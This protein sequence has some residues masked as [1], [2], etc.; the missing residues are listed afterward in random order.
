MDTIGQNLLV[1]LVGVLVIA[2][3]LGLVKIAFRDQENFKNISPYAALLGVI[4]VVGSSTYEFGRYRLVTQ[5]VKES[6]P[7]PG[8]KGPLNI[9][10]AQQ[11]VTWYSDFA[12]WYLNPY[13]LISLAFFCLTGLLICAVRFGIIVGQNAVKLDHLSADE[14]T[15]SPSAPKPRRLQGLTRLGIEA[16]TR[17]R[18]LDWH[19]HKPGSRHKNSE[20]PDFEAFYRKLHKGGIETPP[21]EG[22]GLNLD[23]IRQ[24]LEFLQHVEPFLKNNDL[25]GTCE[26]AAAFVESLKVK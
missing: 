2:A 8:A 25:E 9:T 23:N 1:S 10:H 17:A 16:G 11:V 3:F 15:T 4:G 22:D 7:V 18:Q 5:I 14:E 24:H 13:F 21:I 6:V 26:K 19:R 12:D 20:Q